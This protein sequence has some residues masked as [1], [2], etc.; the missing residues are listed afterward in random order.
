MFQ[1]YQKKYA[2]T[3]IFN[4]KRSLVYFDDIPKESWDEV[5]LINKK[6]T[7]NTVKKAIINAVNEYNENNK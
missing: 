5:R 4:A 1:Y 6:I 3:N 7:A 2:T